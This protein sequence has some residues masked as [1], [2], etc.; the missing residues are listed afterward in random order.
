MCTTQVVVA[1]MW[2]MSDVS[3]VVV[4]LLRKRFTGWA[5]SQQ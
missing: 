4:Q 5:N 1:Q 2:Q 3:D